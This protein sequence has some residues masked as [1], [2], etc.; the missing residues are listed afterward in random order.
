MSKMKHQ[1]Q[2]TKHELAITIATSS[3]MTCHK[4]PHCGILSSAFQKL[5]DCR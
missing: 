5:I 2:E 1:L 4:I 3:L